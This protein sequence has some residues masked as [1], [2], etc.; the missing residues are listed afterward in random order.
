MVSLAHL[1][2]R[3]GSS[4]HPAAP[5]TVSG[6][7]LSG[8]HIS[9]LEDPTAYL[10]GGELLLTTGI[11][12]RGAGSQASRAQTAAYVHRLAAR[13][14]AALGLGLGEGLDAVPPALA[15]A[16]RAES[17][18]LLV[19]PDGVPFM[20]VSRAFWDLA[21]QSGQADLIAGLGTQTALARSALRPDALPA[22][23]KGLAQALGGWAAYLPADGGAE[24][25][26]PTGAASLVPQLRQETLQLNQTGA[27]SAATFG[28]HGTAVVEYPILVGRRIEGFLAIGAGRTL[29]KADRQIIL[30]VCVLLSLKAQQRQELEGTSAALGAAV[31]KL[32]LRGHVEAARLLT[33]DTGLGMLPERVRVLAVRGGSTE[34]L[35]AL[36]GTVALLAADEDAAELAGLL[37]GCRFRLAEDGLGWFLLPAAPAA[38]S[39]DAA[40]G[41][42][43]ARP[44]QEWGWDQDDWEQGETGAVPGPP[45]AAVGP[46]TEGHDRAPQTPRWMAGDGAPPHGAAVTEP[47]ALAD[48]AGRAAALRQA[49]LQAPAGRLVGT[50][51]GADALAD[52]W[53]EQLAGYGRADLLGTVAAYLRRRGHW[54]EAARDLN[55]HRNSLRHRMAV[56]ERLL[57]VSLDDPDAAAHLWL[58]LRRRG[59]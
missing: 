51:G 53:A 46:G 12:L 41:D 55:V 2:S 39:G 6:R 31:T 24:T 45:R 30:T 22:V 32:V 38:G 50:G 27:P 17:L 56:A 11:P 16:C 18:E 34:R 10:E 52:A 35:G 15:E 47:L 58:A 7:Q 36:A 19:V 49:A 8:V 59:L 28:L 9:E 3:L 20:E 5:G 48:V 4:L 1:C 26:W 57:G 25:F 40:G 33:A 13:G 29:A 23:V 21:A 37:A 44:W 54:E 14:V 42:L 43:P